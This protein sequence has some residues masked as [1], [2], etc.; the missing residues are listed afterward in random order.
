M[1]GVKV[2]TDRASCLYTYIYAGKST[3]TDFTYTS[4]VCSESFTGEVHRLSMISKIHCVIS[5]PVSAAEEFRVT[6]VDNNSLWGTYVVSQHGGRK[7]S[8]KV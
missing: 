7:V 3:A 4:H 6:V 2:L 8:C 1:P 5:V